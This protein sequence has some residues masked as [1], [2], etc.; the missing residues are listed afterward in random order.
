MPKEDA[1]QHYTAVIQINK[2]NEA[3]QKPSEFNRGTQ[4]EVPRQVIEIANIVVRDTSLEG[5]TEKIAKHTQLVT[6]I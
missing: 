6:E 4:V 2:V 3:H 1:P 5:L